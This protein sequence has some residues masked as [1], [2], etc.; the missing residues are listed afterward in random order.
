VE[1]SSLLSLEKLTLL[2]ELRLGWC[3][4]LSTRD[5]C[6]LSSL[7]ALRCLHIEGVEMEP[8]ENLSCLLALRQLSLAESFLSARSYSK[9]SHL[10][11]LATL[12]LSWCET[13]TD[14]CVLKLCRLCNLRR[15][16]LAW[17]TQVSD[18]SV[19]HMTTLTR[20]EYLNLENT[21]VNH[22]HGLGTRRLR[23][24]VGIIHCCRVGSVSFETNGS[25]LC[26]EFRIIICV[27]ENQMPLFSV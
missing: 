6:V 13:A 8:L 17:C 9:I 1:D 10:S 26:S 14:H 20:L 24:V 5:L 18:I 2:Q 7:P 23:A 4:S 16:N 27:S 25:I 19:Q 3:R 15:L 11:A 22:G 21:Q 12:D